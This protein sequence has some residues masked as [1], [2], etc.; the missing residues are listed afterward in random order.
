MNQPTA[1]VVD[2]SLTFKRD[3]ANYLT[4]QLDQRETDVPGPIVVG[5]R[6]TNM[7]KM[8]IMGTSSDF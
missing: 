2:G 1:Q 4:R 6:N 7:V 8:A 3:N 5:L